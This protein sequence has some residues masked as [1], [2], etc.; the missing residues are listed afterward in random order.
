MK[1]K[2]AFKDGPPPAGVFKA[3]VSNIKKVD[4]IVEIE[5]AIKSRPRLKHAKVYSTLSK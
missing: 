4:G 3:T 1:T 5:F 2:I